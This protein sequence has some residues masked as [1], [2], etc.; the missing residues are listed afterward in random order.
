MPGRVG[1]HC[2]C[3]PRLTGLAPARTAA[4]LRDCGAVIGGGVAM[5]P[6]AVARAE[7]AVLLLLE[8]HW[9]DH[10]QGL[11]REQLLR[12]LRAVGGEVLDTAVQ[13]LAARGAV[14]RA[15]RIRLLRA[16]HEASTKER[17][18]AA[19]AELAETFRRAGLTPPDPKPSDLATRHA[20]S[21]LVRDGVLV[22]AVDHAHKREFLF[23][24]DAID[25]A[26]RVLTPL[27]RAS[28]PA[29]RSPISVPHSAFRANTACRCWSI[30]TRSTSPAAS[31]TGA[32]CG[33]G[34][35]HVVR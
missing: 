19:A 3:W 7:R 11:T 1:C 35:R 18:G 9:T 8:R 5:T 33:R 21:Q 31:A 29:C 13:Q 24:R 14:Q 27:L 16:E 4:A 17:E 15:A 34:E 12:G 10:K 32:C 20:M 2:R 30:W 25:A 26:R 23:H 6:A 22:R 28:G